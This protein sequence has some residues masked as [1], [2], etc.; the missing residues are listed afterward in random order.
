MLC[1]HPYVYLVFQL[2]FY[3]GNRIVRGVYVEL[4]Y[5]ITPVYFNCFLLFAVLLALH[6]SLYIALMPFINYNF[7]CQFLSGGIVPPLY[8][9]CKLKDASE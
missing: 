1:Y 5:A 8:M 3:C 4:F 7:T 2:F 9:Y 6:L